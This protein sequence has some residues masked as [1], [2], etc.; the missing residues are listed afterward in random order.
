MKIEDISFDEKN[1][2]F[3][4]QLSSDESLKVSYEMY[5]LY[6]LKKSMILSDKLYEVL[7]E[8]DAYI[9]AKQ[10]A[11]RFVSYKQRTVFELERKL[12]ISNISESNINKTVEYFV[13]TGYLN[14]KNY[15]EEFF[16]QCI[17]LK[18]FSLNK[19]KLK[20]Y[21]KGLDKTMLEDIISKQYSE[22]YEFENAM[23]MARKKAKNLDL[24]EP[25]SLEKIY[26]YLIS[27]GFSYSLSK[28]VLEEI[29][30]ED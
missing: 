5:E 4:I 16:R 1:M 13:K 9:K 19:I 8:E 12:R 25:K 21:E 23:T 24:N 14:D 29:K 18:K 15:A 27:N 17:E 2:N 7:K 20:F 11:L 30:N 10:I 22:E 6:E 3:N 28:N 26:R